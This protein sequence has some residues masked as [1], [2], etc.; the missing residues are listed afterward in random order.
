MSSVPLTR[1]DCKNHNFYVFLADNKKL[2]TS[3]LM[4]FV[5]T[6]TLFEAIGCFY[7][8]SPRQERH[9]SLPGKMPNVAMRGQISMN[10]DE[11]LKMRKALV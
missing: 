11:G 9:P 1:P 3:V 6:A 10:S 2:T 7:H 5:H 8:F 4:G